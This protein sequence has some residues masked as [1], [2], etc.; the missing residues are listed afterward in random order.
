MS[1]LRNKSVADSKSV[2]VA[3]WWVKR[4]FRLRDNQAL[5]QAT[6]AFGTVL[7]VFSFEPLLLNGP[8]WSKFHTS[9][10][11]QSVR[12]LRGDLRQ[13]DANLFV[14]QTNILE[15]FEKILTELPFEAV[16]AHEETG[17]NHTFERDRAVAAWCQ[18]RGVAFIE[19]PF[20]GVIR[21]HR[22]RDTWGRKSRK[23]LNRDPL[24]IPTLAPLKQA[25]QRWKRFPATPSRKTLGIADL[26]KTLMQ[27]SEEKAQ[28]DLTQFLSGDYE[29][30]SGNIS[31]M[32]TAPEHCSRLSMHLAWGTLSLSEVLHGVQDE[33]TRVKDD[34]SA[35]R[36]R[37]SL[38]AFRSRVYWHS[39]FV[40]KLENEVSMEFE[41]QNKAFTDV[42]Y[43]EGEELERRL[44]AWRKGGTGFPYV[45]ACMRYYQKH[46]WLNFRG[47]A[48]ITSFACHALRI[49]WWVHQYELA[50]FMMDYVPGINTTQIQM[51]AGVTGTNTLRVYSPTKQMMDHDPEA[52]F[53]RK[54]VAELKGFSKDEIFQFETQALG[55]YPRPVIDFKEEVDLM[56]SAINRIKFSPFGREEAERVFQKHGS[57][58]WSNTKRKR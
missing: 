18:A 16:Y 52:T 28:A 41:P 35:G 21:A 43:V 37:K 15:V 19:I 10:L 32:N 24:P 30:Y 9:A 12:S 34:A 7:P 27:T 29:F 57:R 44:V 56:R 17:L 48:M 42:P 25:A 45:D 3:L 5:T 53:I 8:D 58:R 13:V 40:Q 49:P 20:G 6:T 22:N 47:R 4:D 23:Q 54:H 51:Q 50:K 2:S 55:S 14:G 31:S 39:H 26:P 38:T 11:H 33:F 36:K 1:E 46:G